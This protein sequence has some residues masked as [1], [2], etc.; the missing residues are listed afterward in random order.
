VQV[1]RNATDFKSA[2]QK[3]AKRTSR[4]FV[5]FALPNGLAESRFGLTTPR[6]LGKAHD[7]NRIRR[8]V[9]EIIRAAGGSIPA[10]FDWVINPRRSVLD[11]PFADLRSEL[12]KLLGAS[13]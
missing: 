10:G 8:R 12:L 13:S 5:V 9:R 7:R 2:Y 11:Q 6:K 1:L 3:G 4:S